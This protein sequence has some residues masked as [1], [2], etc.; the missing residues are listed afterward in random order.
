MYNRNIQPQVNIS[1]YV[2]T[3]LDT[4]SQDIKVMLVATDK[5]FGPALVLATWYNKTIL[6]TLS[7]A[8]NYSPIPNKPN[9]IE[10]TINNSMKGI[11]TICEINQLQPSHPIRKFLLQPYKNTFCKPC[12]NPKVPKISAS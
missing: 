2:T 11:R 1:R 12:F 10:S 4:I 3:A 5:N 7:D 6:D 9:T 8:K